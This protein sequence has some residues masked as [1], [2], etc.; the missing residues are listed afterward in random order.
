MK[1][2]EIFSVIAIVRGIGLCT[3]LAIAAGASQ[4]E[5]KAKAKVT[6]ADARAAALAK[7]PGGTIKSAELEEEH[8]KLIWSFDIKDP[9]SRNVIEVNVNAKTARIVSKKIETSAD[10]AKEKKADAAKK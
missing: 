7:V 1:V 10:E 8:G 6:E 3:P 5:L 2:F 9:K 4:D